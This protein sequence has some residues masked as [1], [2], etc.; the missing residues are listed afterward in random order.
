MACAWGTLLSYVRTGTPAYRE[1]FGRPF[2]ED[3]DAHP[4]LGASFDALMGPPGHGTPNPEFQI[5]GGWKSVRSVV[6]VGGV[7]IKTDRLP[8]RLI[9]ASTG[10]GYQGITVRNRR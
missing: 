10:N 4:D 2:W 5:T 8:T 3:R 6:D 9:A 1:L 7:P